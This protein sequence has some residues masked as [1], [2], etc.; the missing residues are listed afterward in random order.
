[1]K[2]K[3]MGTAD[4]R[5][6]EKSDDFA[7]RL[8]EKI[9]VELEWNWENNHVI[10]T[11]DDPYSDLGDEVWEL[12]LSEPDFKDVSDMKRI[13]LSAGEKLWRSLQEPAV[14]VAPGGVAGEAG[15]T[16]SSGSLTGGGGGPTTV[17]GSTTGDAGTTSGGGRKGRAGG[18][19]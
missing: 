3:Y 18:S 16:G 12:V 6:I 8:P 15:P 7:G 17:G 2:I 13:P 4:I 14:N 11:E 19:T 5:R 10:D 1:M 9:G